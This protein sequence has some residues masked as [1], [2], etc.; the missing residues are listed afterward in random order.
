MVGHLKAWKNPCH[1]K[2]Y[3]VI[4]SLGCYVLVT[5]LLWKFGD[6]EMFRFVIGKLA[7]CGVERVGNRGSVGNVTVT[8]DKVRNGVWNSYWQRVWRASSG[9]A[10]RVKSDGT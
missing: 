6:E 1:R 5:G 9:R 4:S 7:G 3:V 2:S 8:V 10:H